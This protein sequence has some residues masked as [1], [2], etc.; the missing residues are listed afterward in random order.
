MKTIFLFLIL[1]PLVSL[2]GVVN[3]GGGKAIVCRDKDRTIQSA[4]VLDLY[5]AQHQYGLQLLPS[6][7][8]LDEAINLVGERLESLSGT[9]QYMMSMNREQLKEIYKKFVLLGPGIGLEPINDS[10]DILR[11]ENCEIEQLAYFKESNIILVNQNIWSKLDPQNQAAL[12][13][14]EAIYQLQRQRGATDSRDSRKIV[15]HLFST[16]NLQN[17]MGPVKATGE[18]IRCETS[19]TQNVF[20]MTKD[21]NG[22]V[23][24]N[25][26]ILGGQPVYS[27]TQTVD[28]KGSNI[29]DAVI[30]LRPQHAFYVPT[31]LTSAIPHRLYDRV[32]F[33]VQSLPLG[34]GHSGHYVELKMHLLT[35]DTDEHDR[36]VEGLP[37]WCFRDIVDANGSVSESIRKN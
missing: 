24:M 36:N 28:I 1:S 21:E 11:P 23:L 6:P 29:Y 8:T 5:E 10:H 25:F 26:A 22:S 4:Q 14:H 31:P 7:I 32:M 18:V 2:A 30:G 37:V 12:I 20:Y 19:D 35:M 16:A 9:R 17:V 3:G 27:L 33:K 13:V 15:G 34:G